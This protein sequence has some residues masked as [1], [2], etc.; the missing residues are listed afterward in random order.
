MQPDAWVST[1]DL[2]QV[3]A[4]AARDLENAGALG[5]VQV[6]DQ[7]VATQQE[8]GPRKVLVSPLHAVGAAHELCV[9]VAV[10]AHAAAASR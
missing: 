8:P 2:G 4:C 7:P 9:A 10:V 6:G 5:R 3:A 1:T